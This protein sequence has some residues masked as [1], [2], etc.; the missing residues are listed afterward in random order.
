M[1]GEPVWKTEN[2][3][4]NMFLARLHMFELTCYIN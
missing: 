1:G 3:V 2:T 4:P